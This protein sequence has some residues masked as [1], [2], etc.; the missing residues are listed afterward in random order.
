MEA[1]ASPFSADLPRHFFGP[2]GEAPI[3]QVTDVL[4]VANDPAVSTDELD[5]YPPILMPSFPQGPAGGPRE[6]DPIQ[7]G[8]GVELTCLP[9]EQAERIMNACSPRGHYFH[10]V[11]QYGQRYTFRR[12]V[13]RE[14]WEAHLYHWDRDGVLGDV[15]QLSR[16]VLDHGWSNEFGARVIVHEDGEQQIVPPY[17]AFPAYRLRSGRDWLTAAEADEL[18]ELL[19]RYEQSRDQLPPRVTQAMWKAEF[20]VRDRWLDTRVPLL[21]IAFEGLIS[22]DKALVSRQFRE[23]V[24]ALAEAAG[25]EG[26]TTQLCRNL[27]GARSRWVHGAHI[28]L[29]PSTPR[30][31]E[32]EGAPDAERSSA[33]L[34]E[35][36]LLQHA[37]RRIIARCIQDAEF[38]ALLEEDASVRARWPVTL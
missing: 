7:L 17:Q 1:S 12:E 10:P 25:V 11:R 8:Q 9:G 29:R 38:A 6:P 36:A 22:T 35:I 28:A 26:V 14:E 23:R 20:M 31:D 27:Y 4:L 33:V 24:P 30:G 5:A 19:A 37:L 3:S 34:D 2:P 13:A 16:L 32:P 15:L 18:A 21:V